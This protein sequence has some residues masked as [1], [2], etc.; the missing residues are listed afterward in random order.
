MRHLIDETF[1]KY[2][3]Y[4]RNCSITSGTWMRQRKFFELKIKRVDCKKTDKR[5][6]KFVIVEKKR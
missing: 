6:F 3:N 5:V 1:V 2:Q 4:V